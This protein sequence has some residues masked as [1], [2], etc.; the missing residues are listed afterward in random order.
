M[1]T[2]PNIFSRTKKQISCI[3]PFWF[4]NGFPSQTSKTS[5]IALTTSKM[6][7]QLKFKNMRKKTKLN[8]GLWRK[9]W[10][11]TISMS[12][13]EII[14]IQRLI[15]LANHI[16]YRSMREYL[17]ISRTAICTHHRPETW[18]NWKKRQIQNRLHTWS[19]SEARVGNRKNRPKM[20]CNWIPMSPSATSMFQST[21]IW[22]CKGLHFRIWRTQIPIKSW[23]N[24]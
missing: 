1:E 15:L 21:S 23:N 14:R 5:M 17:W 8:S 13:R 9:C 12:L 24:K 16:S 10:R 20:K 4:N 7:H 6:K 3:T 11:E 22:I 2:K 18:D 19:W